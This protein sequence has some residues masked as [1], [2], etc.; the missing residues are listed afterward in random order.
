MTLR[1]NVISTDNFDHITN[2]NFPMMVLG[3]SCY[4]HDSA[5][6]LVRDGEI[7]AAVQEERFSRVKNDSSFPSNALDW[8]MESNRLRGSDIDAVVFYEKPFLKFERIVENAM[9]CS[10]KGYRVFKKSAPS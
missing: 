3:I 7:I 9:L 2:Y 5:V 4:Y 10:P 6:A 1:T 8:I